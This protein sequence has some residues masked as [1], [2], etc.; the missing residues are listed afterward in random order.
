MFNRKNYICAHCGTVNQ[1]KRVNSGTLLAELLI[2]ILAIATALITAG[3]SILAAIIYS[4]YRLFS[5]KTVCA[6]CRHNELID[7]SSPRG[8]K[9]IDE[10]TE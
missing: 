10:Y 5:K 4:G 6:A 9:L 1:I 2:W 8:R 3:F 7:V